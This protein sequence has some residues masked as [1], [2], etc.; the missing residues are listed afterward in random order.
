MLTDKQIESFVNDGYIRLEGAFSQELAAQARAILWQDLNCDEHDPNTWTHPV[1]RLGMYA[2]KAFQLAANT[3]VLHQA[4][5]HLVGPGRWLARGSLGTFPVRF[6]HSGDPGDAGWHIDT[7]FE[8]KSGDPNDFLNWRANLTSK[9]RALLMLFL[10]SDVGEEDAPTR[11]RIGSH[12]DIAAGSLR[13]ERTACL[14]E[15][16]R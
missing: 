2:Q 4:F 12:L 3:P 14:S 1:I 5:D 9:G 11:I 13:R 8:P 16:L 6:P 15:N 7:S 10:F